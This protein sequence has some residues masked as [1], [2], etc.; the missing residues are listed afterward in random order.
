MIAF[1]V[2][3]PANVKKQMAEIVA[4]I[5][6][7][8]EDR[9][10]AWEKRLM[11]ALRGLGRFHGHAVDRA[12]SDRFGQTVQRMVFEGAYLVHYQVDEES[13][14]VDVKNLRH[15]KRLPGDEEP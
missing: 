11:D 8:D 4:F 5:A 3:V 10:L 6:D 7:E 14:A 1:A 13:L 12:A 9:A 2:N 15:G